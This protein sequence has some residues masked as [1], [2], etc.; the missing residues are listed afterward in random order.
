VSSAGT[1]QRRPKDI[2]ETVAFDVWG[3]GAELMAFIATV[4][5]D[6]IEIIDGATALVEK[7]QTGYNLFAEED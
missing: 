6:S 1:Y 2:K 7:N 5:N 4:P 3:W